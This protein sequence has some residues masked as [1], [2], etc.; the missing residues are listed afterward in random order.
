MEHKGPIIQGLGAPW[1]WGPEPKC[2]QSINQSHYFT[3]WTEDNH[4]QTD[5]QQSVLRLMSE[6]GTWHIRSTRSNHSTV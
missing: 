2:N 5:Q 6:P 1:P 3:G 4:M